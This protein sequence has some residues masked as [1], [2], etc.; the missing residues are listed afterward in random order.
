PDRPATAGST[1][2]RSAPNGS[3]PGGST[4]GA[5]FAGPMRLEDCWLEAFVAQSP[6]LAAELA[7]RVLGPLAE[8]GPVERERLLETARTHLAGD[9]AIAETAAALYCHRNTIQHR[10]AR[11]RQLTGRDI[12]APQ[13][14]AVIALALRAAALHPE[15]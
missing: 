12:R 7:E 11:F 6:E 1:P 10:F 15:T 8:I 13:D 9:G 3:A 4:G 14:A 2:G 5:S